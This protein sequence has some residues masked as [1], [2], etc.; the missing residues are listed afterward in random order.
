MKNEADKEIL[1]GLIKTANTE[2]IDTWSRN[3]AISLL[4]NYEKWQK[5]ASPKQ[6]AFARDL[7]VSAN[8]KLEKAKVEAE[9]FKNIPSKEVLVNGDRKVV[10]GKVVSLKWKD[11]GFGWYRN[12]SFYGDSQTLKVLLDIGHG[13][14]LWISADSQMAVGEEWSSKMTI[15]TTE[16]P[17]FLIGSRPAGWERLTSGDIFPPLPIFPD[18][19]PN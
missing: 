19:T 12:N 9:A 14:K 10:S 5:F 8:A 6:K 17:T 13:R 3:T 11:T 1:A 15:K 16:D 7:P 4:R 18:V 2:G